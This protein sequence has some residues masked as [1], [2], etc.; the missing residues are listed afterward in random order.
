MRTLFAAIVVFLGCILFWV[1]VVYA[2]AIFM[3]WATS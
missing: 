1:I 3:A 2:I